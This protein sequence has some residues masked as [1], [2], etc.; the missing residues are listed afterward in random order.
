MRFEIYE[1]LLITKKRL[2]LSKKGF[3]LNF[4]FVALSVEMSFKFESSSKAIF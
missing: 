1:H 2:K 4:K 3:K